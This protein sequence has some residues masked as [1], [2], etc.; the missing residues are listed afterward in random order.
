MQTG[1][2]PSHMPERTLAWQIL[3]WAEKYIVQPDGERAGQPWQFTPEQIRFLAWWYAVD[4][5]GRWLYSSG[6]LRRSK[7]WGKSPVL[8]AL[9]VIEFLGPCRF[10][11]WDKQG[12]PVGK[13]VAMP[14]VNLAA[15]SIDQ[16]KNVM[17][18]IRG[19]LAESPA[20]REYDLDIGKSIIQF[21]GG[22]P[23]RIEP[24]T[25]SSRGLE[26]SRQTFVCLDESHHLV[27]ANQG[28]RVYEVLDRNVRKTAGAGSRLLESTNAFNPLEGS[29]A[30]HTHEAFLAGASRLLYDC[31]EASGDIDLRDVEAVTAG[32]VEAY[33]DSY[34]VDVESIVEAIQDPRT[35]AAVAYRFYLNQIKESADG[36][37]IKSEWDA[38]LSDDDPIKPKDQIAIGF[39]G[40]IRGDA[41][42]IVGCRLRD[43]KLFKL[44]LWENP[45]D[46]KRSDWE[47]DVLAVEAAVANAFVLSGLIIPPALVPTIFLL[48]KLG[49]YKTIPGLIFVEVAFLIPFAI[50]VFR[51]FMATIP[52]EIDEAAIVDGASPLQIFFR[53]ILPLLWPAIVTVIVLTSVIVYSDFTL[54]TYFLPGKENITVQVTLFGFMSQFGSQW[55]LMFAAVLI[56]T[57]PPL[58]LFLF[59]QRQ[60]VSGLTA[61]AIR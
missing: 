58:I 51:A 8:A 38:C 52:R 45:R 41:T 10:S 34:W 16:T 31:V 15:T 1:N 53:I 4:E 9:C 48:Q 30:Q 28:I 22:R 56:I 32:V 11:H 19:M 37:M 13:R 25:S 12:N 40:S 20:E 50:L 39:D 55:N 5:N 57:I 26:G 18:A 33:A 42:G 14:L 27:E 60:I 43:G 2:I 44:G 7:G 29:V 61:G 54:P 35:P 49:I 6:S 17:D 23:G 3:A 36:W 21:K 59:F 24:V 46:P 47:V